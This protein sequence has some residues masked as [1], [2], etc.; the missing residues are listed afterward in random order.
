MNHAHFTFSPQR[1][2]YYRKIVHLSLSPIVF[3]THTLFFWVIFH[4][5][6]AGVALTPPTFRMYTTGDILEALG[7]EV[8]VRSRDVGEGA[9][10]A[11]ELGEVEPNTDPSNSAD[12]DGGTSTAT[13]RQ[14]VSL[15]EIQLTWVGGY[16]HVLG[17]LDSV[18]A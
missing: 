5:D 16:T 17:W 7:A 12:S 11:V 18:E 2:Q 15:V 8:M 3:T 1:A 14:V 10:G 4:Q 13:R 9:A 6:L